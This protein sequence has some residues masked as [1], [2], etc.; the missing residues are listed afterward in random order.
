MMIIM[1]K[2]TPDS[3]LNAD[4][5]GSNFLSRMSPLFYLYEEQKINK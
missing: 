4:C 2:I 5:V 3:D 1:A